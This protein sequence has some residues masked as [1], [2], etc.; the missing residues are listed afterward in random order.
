MMQVDVNGA[1]RQLEPSSI[2]E[3]RGY[4]SGVVPA[5]EVICVLRVNGQEM[6]EEDLHGVDVPTIET[7]EVKS[8]RPQALARNA[9]PEAIDWTRRL[10]QVLTSIAEDY[11]SGEEQRAAE[12]LAPASDALQV[13]VGLIS[14]IR[15]FGVDPAKEKE[16]EASWD[17]AVSEF[18]TSLDAFV[19]EFEAGDPIRLADLLGH[20]LPNVLDRFIGLMEST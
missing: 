19:L 16:L 14:G 18:R 13:L 2:D 1:R 7:L 11:R 8:A 3:L 4:L 17:E 9:L 5:D 10:R 12:R 20:D 15:E 6:N